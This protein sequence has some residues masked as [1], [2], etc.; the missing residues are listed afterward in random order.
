MQ[1]EVD[2]IS[3]LKNLELIPKDLQADLLFVNK[4][5]AVPVN[6]KSLLIVIFGIPTVVR[7]KSPKP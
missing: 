4:T 7:Q 5:A 3:L 6:L 1:P 2:V